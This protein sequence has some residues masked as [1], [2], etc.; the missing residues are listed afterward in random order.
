MTDGFNFLPLPE[1]LRHV[2][3][4]CVR[5]RARVHVCVCVGVKRRKM[6]IPSRC[7]FNFQKNKTPLGTRLHTL[8]F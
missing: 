5:V 1:D 7:V 4:A 8:L 3:S 2:F 6:F